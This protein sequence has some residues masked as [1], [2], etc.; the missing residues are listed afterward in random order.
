MSFV[1]RMYIMCNFE[2]SE[3]FKFAIHNQ[4][5]REVCEKGLFMDI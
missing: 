2:K 1:G 4:M 3:T 5:E